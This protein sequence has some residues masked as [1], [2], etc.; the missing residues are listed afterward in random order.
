MMISQKMLDAINDQINFEYYSYW[1][2]QAMTFKMDSMGLKIFTKWFQQQSDEEVIH[3]MKMSNYLLDQGA[4]V[5]LSSLEA[6][7]NNYK[8][9]EEIVQTALDHEL[10][11]TKRINK[12]MALARDEDDFATSAFMQ[13]FVD[14][15]VEEV[16]T[17]NQLLDMVRMCDSS[18]QLLL[19]EDRIMSLR[20][21]SGSE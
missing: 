11:V 12:L 10:E 17:V 5:K 2:Y 20:E 14:E 9:V 19:L 21:S 6:P 13:W 7:R 18:G 15:Q 4:E 8:D 1:V 3:A 16:A